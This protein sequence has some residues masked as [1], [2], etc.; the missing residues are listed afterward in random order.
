MENE[1]G[2]GGGV[3]EDLRRLFRSAE[4]LLWRSAMS[5]DEAA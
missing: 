2:G 1:G 3:E 4:E 5:E